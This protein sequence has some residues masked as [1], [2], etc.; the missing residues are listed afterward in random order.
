[1]DI[2]TIDHR[3]SSEYQPSC[4]QKVGIKLAFCWYERADSLFGTWLHCTEADTPY[5]DLLKQAFQSAW[6][7]FQRRYPSDSSLQTL[8]PSTTWDFGDV[9]QGHVVTEKYVRSPSGKGFYK[10]L[11]PL[12]GVKEEKKE[13]KKISV[14]DRRTKLTNPILFHYFSKTHEEFYVFQFEIANK[15]PLGEWYGVYRFNSDKDVGAEV[16]L[17]PSFPLGLVKSQFDPL[18]RQIPYQD[19]LEPVI[20]FL[21]FEEKIPKSLG[22]CTI[23]STC[24]NLVVQVTLRGKLEEQKTGPTI[25]PILEE[26]VKDEHDVSLCQ[27]IV[28]DQVDYYLFSWTEEK[29]SLLS[30][31]WKSFFQEQKQL[32][33]K[34]DLLKQ[35]FTKVWELF[36]TTNTLDC[37][38]VPMEWFL[39]VSQNLEDMKCSEFGQ[40]DV[41]EETGDRFRFHV[42]LKLRK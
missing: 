15:S 36:V 29:R 7:E 32:V 30:L 22:I 20:S 8:K 16:N 34:C 17:N 1:M 38:L 11:V 27:Q 21:K 18:W 42:P 35:T 37:D 28:S 40:V 25:A 33:T 26:V 9:R 3:P 41:T 19:R 5:Q 12:E 23:Y 10:V 31:W 14:W 4:L 39:Y 2:Q 24:D 6:E 13:N